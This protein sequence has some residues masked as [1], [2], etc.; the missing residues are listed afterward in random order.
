[1]SAKPTFFQRLTAE[2]VGTGWV[3]AGVIGSGIMASRLAGGNVGIAMIG[4]VSAIAAILYVAIVVMRPISGAHFNPV[5]SLV[6]AATRA[7]PAREAAGY[8]AAQV[9]GALTG[10]VVAHLMFGQTAIQASDIARTGPAQWFSEVIATGGLV[11]AIFLSHRA[12]DRSVPVV[13]SAYVFAACWFTGSACFIN[14]AMTLARGLTESMAGIRL[15]DVP[16]F[17]ICQVAGGFAGLLLSN[18]ISSTAPHRPR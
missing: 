2:F 8:I 16:A 9:V 11:L 5:V 13:A 12:D 14:P 10:A 18:V 6:L 4:H 15:S 7:L 3:L 1:M 17:A